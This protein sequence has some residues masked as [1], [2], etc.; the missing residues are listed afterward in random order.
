MRPFFLLPMVLAVTACSTAEKKPDRPPPLVKVEPV[1]FHQFSDRY[2]A[3]GTAIANEQVTVTAP[4]T[5]RIT[6][7]GFSDGDYVRTGQILA[8]LAQGQETASLASAAARAR[9]AE[10]Q[11]A[12]IAALRERGFAT[13]SSLDAQLATVAATRAGASEARAVIADRVIR[14]PFS[15][16]V[17]LRRISVGAVVSAGTEIATISDSSII[18]LDF[19]IPETLLGAVRP[20]LPILARAA[21]YP[22]SPVSGTISAIDP[23]I[24]PTTRAVMVRALIPNPVGRL[25]PG[26]LLSVALQSRLRTAVAV[27]ELAMVREGDGRFVYMVDKDGKAKRITVVTGGRDGN[28]IEV[29]QG[30]NPGDRIVTEGVVKLSE[31]TKVRVA[32]DIQPA[33]PDAPRR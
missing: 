27:P 22:D 3:V 20:G 7:L 26:M 12:R 25:K 14:A 29:T 10:Q 21:A 19:S 23:V 1:S 31:G 8:V 16:R 17:S 11:L 4:V 33:K 32:E 2:E 28:L 24:D 18:K 13:K 30:I 15:G 9:E 6:R 5:E